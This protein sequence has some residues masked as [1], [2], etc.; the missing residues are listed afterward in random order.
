LFAFIFFLS[1][2]KSRK[3]SMKSIKIQRGY[4]SQRILAGAEALPP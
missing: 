2:H 1:I 4:S 3:Y